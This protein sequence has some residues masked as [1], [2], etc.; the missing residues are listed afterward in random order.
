MANEEK[1]LVFS[2]AKFIL[3]WIFALGAAIYF[4]AASSSDNSIL[5]KIAMGGVM[6]VL[7]YFVASL[8]GF[9]LRATGNYIVAAV[10]F[11]ILFV[12]LVFAE[13]YIMGLGKTAQ[14]IGGIVIIVGLIWLPI[15]DMRKAILYIKNTV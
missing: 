10:L 2:P 4:A 14:L 8:F 6:F 13:S 1:V 9:S 7:F 12:L 3:K 15:N 11:V 5:Y